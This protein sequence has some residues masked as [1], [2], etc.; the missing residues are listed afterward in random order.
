M[1][2]I[3]I[4]A[5]A[6]FAIAAATALLRGLLAFSRIGDGIRDG[7]ADAYL[8]RGKAQNRMMSQRV[9]F[10]ALAILAATALGLMFSGH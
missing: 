1:F 3:L 9:L 10:Q 7:D 6:L 2:A 4:V 5:I 8:R